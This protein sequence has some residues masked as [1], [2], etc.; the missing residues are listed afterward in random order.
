MK[1]Y[2]EGTYRK[3]NVYTNKFEFI[4]IDQVVLRD[5]GVC[6]SITDL[7]P[8]PFGIEVTGN[9]QTLSSSILG[10]KWKRFLC[11]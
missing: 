11:L 8:A 10:K 4:R 9:Q 5:N 2:K 6:Y 3:F 1:L 7:K